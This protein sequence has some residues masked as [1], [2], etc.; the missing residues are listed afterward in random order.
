VEW[1]QATETGVHEVID[2]QA[3]QRLK[4]LICS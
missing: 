1:L 4:G 3:R 2:H